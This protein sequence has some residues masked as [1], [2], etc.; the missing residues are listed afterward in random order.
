M[1]APEELESTTAAIAVEVAELART[2]NFTVAAAESLTGGK[3]AVQFS[4]AP[5]SSAWFAG[6]VVSYQSAVKHRALGVPEGPV[7]SEDA[8]IAMASGAARL[9]GADA[10]VAVTGS[11]GPG[12]QEGNPPGTAWLAAAVRG[13]VRTALHH[14]EG[15]P[16]EVLARTQVAALR[17]LHRTMHDTLHDIRARGDRR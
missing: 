3:I 12:E 4:A 17:L 5:D 11:G 1:T 6:A 8:A 14:F 9:L 7:I 10:V 16:V 15:D 2:H 13:Q